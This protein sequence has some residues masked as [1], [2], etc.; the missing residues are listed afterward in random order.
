MRPDSNSFSSDLATIVI[1]TLALLMRQTNVFW[2]VVW[3]GGLQAVHAV[4]TLR[5]GR[6]DQPIFTTV[7]GQ[8]RFFAWRLLRGR[9]P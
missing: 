7:W 1:G 4:K 6:V 5:P 2:I 8:M 3:M 9:H